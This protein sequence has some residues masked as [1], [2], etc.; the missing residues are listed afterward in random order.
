MSLRYISYMQFLLSLRASAFQLQMFLVLIFISQHPLEALPISQGKVK[1]LY[2]SLD[3]YSISQH[4]AFYELYGRTQEG[5]KAFHHAL[6][7]LSGENNQ[8][9]SS[10]LSN[11]LFNMG[12]YE[13]VNLVNKDPMSEPINLNEAQLTLIEYLSLNLSNRKLKGFRAKKEADVLSLAPSEIDLGRGLLLSQF[14]D[15]ESHS[16]KI[17]PYEALLDLMALQILVRIP[18]H[19]TPEDIIRG[20]NDF[21]FGEIGFRFPAHSE[22]AKDIDVYTFL[23]SVLDK[24]RGVCLGVSILYICLAQRLNLNLQ[25]ITPPGHIFIRHH[26]GANEINIETTARGVHIPSEEYLSVDTYRLQE[27]NIKDVIGFTY[28]NQ[29]S[30]YVAEENYSQALSSYKKAE[31]YLEKDPH[32][33]ELIAYQYLLLGN[34]KEGLEILKLLKDQASEFEIFKDTLSEDFING[35]VNSQGIKVFFQTVDEKRESIISKRDALQAVVHQYPSFRAGLFSLATTWLQL[36]RKREAL[37]ALEKYHSL[38]PNDP[39]AEYYL[40]VL[41]AERLNYSKAWSHL[42]N[43]EK[44][45]FARNYHP[46]VLK[47]V[48]RELSTLCPE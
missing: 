31:L 24:R 34:E 35:K 10:L 26:S 3:P 29:A 37:S 43:A 5:K 25:M 18:K 8:S 19:P 32:L 4:L 41:H 27:R 6:S 30:V 11:S 28:Y 44:I 36:H 22:Y 1:A 20:I 15:F 39:T 33:Q 2:S 48:R 13:I 40:T 46:K 38:E 23:P 9:I 16:K 42:Q 47:E 45:V 7:L 21:I 17:R 14:G 12:V